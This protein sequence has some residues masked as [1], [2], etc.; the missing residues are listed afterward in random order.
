MLDVRCWI[1]DVSSSVPGSCQ[2]GSFCESVQQV[3]V[4]HRGAGRALWSLTLP[5]ARSAGYR[6]LV[7]QVRDTNRAAQRFYQRLGFVECGRLA[8]QV[9]VDG[10]EEDEV[11]M[12]LFL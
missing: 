3:K 9:I 4:L 11:L 5:F 7:I 12:E 6:K 10:R 1:F 2:C 8:R